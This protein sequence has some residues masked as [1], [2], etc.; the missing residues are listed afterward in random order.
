MEDGSMVIN[1]GLLKQSLLGMLCGLAVL[2]TSAAFAGDGVSPYLSVYGGMAFPE[3]L[4]DVQGR[5]SL[6]GFT[7]SDFSLKSRPHGWRKIWN[8][9]KE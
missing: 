6:S 1:S 9:G 2:L 4:H 3:S 5:G 8:Y 7:F